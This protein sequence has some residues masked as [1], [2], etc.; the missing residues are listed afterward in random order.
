MAKQDFVG[1]SSRRKVDDEC[2]GNML[3]VD[4]MQ[5]ALLD[6]TFFKMWN[7]KI[8]RIGEEFAVRMQRTDGGCCSLVWRKKREGRG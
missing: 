2:A 5:H 3:S 7:N 6:C 8:D 1:L 4:S